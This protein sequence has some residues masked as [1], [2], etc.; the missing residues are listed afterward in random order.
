MQGSA[1]GRVLVAASLV[2]SIVA[3]TWLD[4]PYEATP[5]QHDAGAGGNGVT[6]RGAAG[7]ASGSS[8]PAEAAA[9]A[10]ACSGAV[11]SEVA[12]RAC[13]QVIVLTEPASAAPVAAAPIFDAGSPPDAAILASRACPAGLGEFGAPELV[14]TGLTSTGNFFG[15]ALSADGLQL[16]FS[17]ALPGSEQ[18]YT[19]RRQGLDTAVFSE[20]TEVAAV[21]SAALD[22]SPFVSRDERRIYFFSDRNAGAG[23][24]D[25]WFSE[26]PG[27]GAAFGAPVLLAGVNTGSF[28]HLPWLAPD[29]LSILFVSSRPNGRNS[30]IWSATR[31]NTAAPFGAAVNV[32]SLSSVAT[33]GRVALSSDGLIAIFSSDRPGGLGNADIWVASRLDRSSPF[34]A[35]SNLAQLNSRAAD[36]DV[37]L[38]SDE[39]ELFF[40]SARN[41]VSLLWRST[42]GCS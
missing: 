35:P 24:R 32:A 23:G 2:A 18:I 3:C 12:S 19:A 21:N 25:I 39:R 38:S 42:R 16:Y 33:E 31:P 30:D 22:G 36:L 5:L 1:Q 15:P 29:E 8:A 14:T 27:A 41:G 11:D 10:T 6:Q 13:S 26:R 17:V 28:E 40:A 20:A 7:M 4:D 9:A 37:V 34:A